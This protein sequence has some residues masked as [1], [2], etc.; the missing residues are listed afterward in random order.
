MVAKESLHYCQHR[1]L[2]LLDQEAKWSPLAFILPLVERSRSLQH[3]LVVLAN[4]HRR[5]PKEERLLRKS[6]ALKSF[7]RDLCVMDNPIRLAVVMILLLSESI[8]TERGV[9][10][11]HLAAVH[12]IMELELK[13]HHQ[14][15]LQL[16]QF[17]QV[18]YLQFHYWDIIGSLLSQQ[19]PQLSQSNL[20]SICSTGDSALDDMLFVRFGVNRSILRLLSKFA[21]EGPSSINLGTIMKT[22]VSSSSK[23]RLSGFSVVACEERIMI[24]QIWIHAIATYLWTSVSPYIAPRSVFEEHAGVVFNYAARLLSTRILEAGNQI[25]VK[26]WVICKSPHRRKIIWPLIIAGS[27]TS[28]LERR[29]LIRKYCDDSY[30]ETGFGYFKIAAEIEAEVE[31]RR[32]R[33]EKEKE[34]KGRMAYSCWRHVT[35]TEGVEGYM[36]G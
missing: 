28:I 22:P 23:L 5:C 18:L 2:G 11:T 15:Y 12:R 17:H 24:E 9:W 14:G 3:A 36:I 32:K 10:R 8:D 30:C 26:D 7:S 6:I 19:P 27:C 1:L 20:Q 31:M 34:E 21:Y 4:T 16:S 35:A 29:L 33:E 13:E 25:T